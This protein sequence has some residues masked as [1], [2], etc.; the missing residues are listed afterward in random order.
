MTLVFVK[1]CDLENSRSYS[2]GFKYAARVR[3]AYKPGCIIIG[4]IHIDNNTH[5]IPLYWYVLVSN[6]QEKKMKRTEEQGRKTETDKNVRT[7]KVSFIP[8]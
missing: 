2:C 6:L 1:S 4:V 5:K 3:C 8:E 7:P